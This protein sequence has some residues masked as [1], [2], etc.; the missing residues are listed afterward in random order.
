[1]PRQILGISRIFTLHIQRTRAA[2]FLAAEGRDAD[3][4]KPRWHYEEPLAEYVKG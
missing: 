3:F 1:M 4:V 2:D